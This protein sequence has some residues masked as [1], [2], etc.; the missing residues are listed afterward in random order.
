MKESKDV[1]RAGD[2]VEALR[3]R[4]VDLDAQFQEDKDNLT[5]QWE[6]DAGDLESIII[7]PKKT[8]ISITIV[9]LAWVPYWQDS[10]GDM[11][12]AWE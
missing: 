6:E 4:L 3:E 5:T 12:P 2:T 9:T 11:T 7:R 1:A 10:S 8:N